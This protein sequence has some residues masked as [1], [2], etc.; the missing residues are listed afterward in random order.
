MTGPAPA[1]PWCRNKSYDTTWYA[2]P[3][4][5]SIN[6]LKRYCYPVNSSAEAMTERNMDKWTRDGGPS[7][8]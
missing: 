6:S 4:I 2:T 1:L 7:T 8:T 3:C 5:S